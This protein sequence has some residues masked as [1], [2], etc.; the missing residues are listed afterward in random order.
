MVVNQKKTN[1]AL[2]V[3][4]CW[5][6]FWVAPVQVY[7]ASKFC[8]KQSQQEKWHISLHIKPRR[9][10]ICEVMQMLLWLTT[11]S[12]VSTQYLTM[13]PFTPNCI[14]FSIAALYFILSP[15]FMSLLLFTDLNLAAAIV[16]LLSLTMMVMGSI[17][18]AMSL[19]KGV[20]FFLKPASFCFI[21]SGEAFTSIRDMVL[22]KSHHIKCSDLMSNSSL[23]LSRHTGPSLYPDIPPVCAGPS[24][25]QPHHTITPWAVL[26]S[27]LCRL[28][29]SSSYFRRMP[30]CHP[31]SSV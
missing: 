24:V 9:V 7:I 1:L 18:I 12:Q 8:F 28:S 17:C 23:P 29:G 10:S 22:Q 15:L 25:Q 21:L 14:Q 4:K 27:G 11:K 6:A 13:L 3:V 19:S 31:L 5:S 16:A 20:Q 26:V 2:A 30:L